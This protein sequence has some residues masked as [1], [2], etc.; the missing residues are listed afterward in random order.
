M[1]FSRYFVETF[2]WQGDDAR[3]RLQQRAAGAGAGRVP[4]AAL[5]RQEEPLQGERQ[6]AAGLQVGHHRGPEPAEREHGQRR[7]LL[8]ESQSNNYPQYFAV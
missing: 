5:P 3:P 4:G 2:N 7:G 1:G 6:G 8:E